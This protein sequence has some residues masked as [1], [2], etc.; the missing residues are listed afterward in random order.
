MKLIINNFPREIAFPQRKLC[1]NE[2]QFYKLVNRYNKLRDIY[3]SLYACGK[4]QDF[5]KVVIDKAI[6][7]FD[8]AD[9]NNLIPQILKLSDYLLKNNIKHLLVFS[10]NKG[11][12]VYVFTK[13]GGNLN[14]PKDAL[15]NF[16]Y[17]IKQILNITPDTKLF[18]DIKRIFRM[19]NTWH[20]IGECYCIPITRK[21]LTK[22]VEHIKN[23]AAKQCFNFKIYGKELLNLAPYD[24]LRPKPLPL[25]MIEA[26][27][28]IEVNDGV[29][30]RMPYCMK[31]VLLNV[32]NV[33]GWEGR[34]EFA[35]YCRDKGFPMN[36][37]DRIAQKYFG[38]VKR[39]DNLNNNYEHFNKVKALIYAY[40]KGE[41]VRN[42]ESL[43]E[44]G[45]C[46]G[47]CD[48]YVEGGFPLYK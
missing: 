27:Y 44:M 5:D 19:P 40:S 22:G 31:R 45:I 29:L 39:G 25:N 38:V 43:Y 3:Y 11:F 41:F 34:Y 37:T 35:K 36:M 10:G 7:D 8:D 13:N 30:N 21:D 17:Y 42:C 2:E 46:K 12:H 20:T 18:G 48:K 6:F 16:H 24:K 28:N 1:L 9:L 32:D 47:K 33:G 14:Y 4:E 23:K 15:Y 26:D